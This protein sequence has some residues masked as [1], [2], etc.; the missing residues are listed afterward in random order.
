[1]STTI[2]NM[3]KR[4]FTQIISDVVEKKL[5]EIFADPDNGLI[6]REIVRKQLLQQLKEVNAGKRGK[7]I[8]DVV[9]EL[10]LQ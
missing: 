1:M 3:T 2:A 9:K 7:N 5:L 4:E 10:G 6:L 8:D